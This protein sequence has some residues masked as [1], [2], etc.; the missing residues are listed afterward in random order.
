M[1]TLQWC[2]RS[3]A[4]QV[5]LPCLDRLCHHVAANIT[6]LASVVAPGHNCR[7]V[8]SLN[9]SFEEASNVCLFCSNKP[10]MTKSAFS[11]GTV[12]VEPT[13]HPTVCSAASNGTPAV[14]SEAFLRRKQEGVLARQNV[15]HVHLPPEQ[16]DSCTHSQFQDV[17][18][19]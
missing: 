10:A 7:T 13:L 18:T 3:V 6:A 19:P 5:F 14:C 9:R 12:M 11:N 15:V 8:V 1:I 2:E 4:D 17:C 16:N